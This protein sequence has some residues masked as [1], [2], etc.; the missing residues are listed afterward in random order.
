MSTD[1]EAARVAAMHDALD[2]FVEVVA[3]LRDGEWELS[4]GCPGWTVKDIVAHVVGLEDVFTGGREPDVE[5]PDG[6]EHVDNDVSRYTEMHVQLRRDRSPQELVDELGVVVGR[7]RDQLAGDLHAMAPSF[8]GGKQPVV[9]GLG[10]R[11]F[12]IFSHEQDVRRS[13]QRAGHLDGPAAAMYLKRALRGL[14]KLLPD[15]VLA[16]EA[17][18]VID[19]VGDQQGSLWLDLGTGDVLEQAPDD[20][21][22]SMRFA[23]G[24][25]VPL[26]GGREDAPD[27]ASVAVVTGNDSLAARV[28]TS[29]GLTP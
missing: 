4:T 27:P 12:D 9:T 21:T 24:D 22:V 15:R 29:L 18:L 7:R 1:R 16:D 8:L 23:F 28:L 25:L 5:L 19:V 13:V 14:G 26:T 20:P 6:L 10:L 17:T 3:T 11:T 2:G